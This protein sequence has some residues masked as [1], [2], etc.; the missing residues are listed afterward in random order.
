MAQAQDSATVGL[1]ATALRIT[2]HHNRL[3]L[4][5]Q[6]Q[7]QP[8]ACNQFSPNVPTTLRACEEIEDSGSPRRHLI[9]GDCHGRGNVLQDV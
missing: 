2:P 6:T 4:S 9:A 1:F 8:D 5:R 7:T 3:A